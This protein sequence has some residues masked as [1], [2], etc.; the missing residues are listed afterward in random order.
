MENYWNKCVLGWETCGSLN[1][2]KM[3][4]EIVSVCVSLIYSSCF[5]S[6]IFFLLQNQTAPT[7]SFSPRGKILWCFRRQRRRVS[8]PPLSALLASL[9]RCATLS[10]HS[11]RSLSLFFCN[12]V[13]LPLAASLFP[14][15]L[16]TASSLS[17]RLYSSVL[18]SVLSTTIHPSLSLSFSFSLLSLFTSSPHSFRL[19]IVC[20]VSVWNL[21]RLRCV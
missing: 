14:C 20:S 13:L 10:A 2:N 12:S 18:L 3:S 9:N 16:F 8:H 19:A 17:S 5:S 7:S 1:F 11:L 6:S 4:T 21:F 15:S